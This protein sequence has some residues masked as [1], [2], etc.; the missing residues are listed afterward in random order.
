MD[1]SRLIL[2]TKDTKGFQ[3][4]FKEIIFNKDNKVKSLF[5]SFKKDDEKIVDYIDYVMGKYD[6]EMNSLMKKHNVDYDESIN[7]ITKGI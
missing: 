2:E 1:F 6:K 4:E 5:N 3:K 7:L